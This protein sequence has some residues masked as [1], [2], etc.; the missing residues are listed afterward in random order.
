MIKFLFPDNFIWGSATS[1]LQIE[2]A[3]DA[4][5]RGPSVW[6]SFCREHPEKIYQQATPE[7]ACDHYRKYAEDV[8]LIKQFG[9]NGYRMSISWPRI[10]PSGQK[11]FNNAGADFYSRLFDFLLQNGIEPNVTLYHWDLPQYLADNGGWENPATID[12]FVNYSQKC[13]ELYAD[14][15]K[16]W[17]TI[18]EP[19]W[20]TLNG[21]VT[22]LHPPCRTDYK[23]AVQV[24]TNF[25]VAHA[26]AANCFH[27]MNK[28]GKIGIALNMSPVYP[29][30]STPEDIAAA[31]LAD[32]IFNAWFSEI[33]LKGKFPQKAS[34]LYHKA[35]IFPNI[36]DSDMNLFENGNLLDFIGVNYYYPHYATSEAAET[37]FHLNTSGNRN[38][39]CMFS[40]EGL[41]RFVKNPTGIYTDW[42]W[43]IKPEVLY[44]LLTKIHSL[45]PGLPVYITENGIG[46][47]ETLTD[48]TVQ[49]DDRIEFVQSH[50]EAIHKAISAGINVRGY[51]MWSLLD[52]FSWIN[53]F[54][55]RYG[56]FFVDRDTMMRFPKKSAHWYRNVAQNNGF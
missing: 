39:S 53:G 3:S 34:E 18:N 35:G 41:F 50:L 22:A 17:S 1:A 15:V 25:L 33:L 46:K 38:E 2:G 12:A 54:K 52:N 7:I 8:A 21:Y 45:A 43:E 40:I 27:S 23:A 24:A 5:G 13:F 36:S 4:D 6:D 19:A 32:S 29:A 28:P 51:Y 9:H 20:T 26:R 55:K 42:A 10:F 31:E 30:T 14:R 56:F 47:N 37:S 11:D 16:L 48:G 49:D 44:D